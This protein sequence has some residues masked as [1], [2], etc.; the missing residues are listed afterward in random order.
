ML[1][2]KVGHEPSALVVPF[3]PPDLQVPVAPS[4]PPAPQV[5]LAPSAP[6][7]PRAQLAPSAPEVQ[8]VPLAPLGLSAP[9]G[10]PGFLPHQTVPPWCRSTSR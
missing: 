2:T 8:L 1:D 5:R 3:V 10:V 4:D 6:L 7:I 9:F